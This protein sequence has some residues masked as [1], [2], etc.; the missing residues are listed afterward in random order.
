[1]PR[2]A[3]ARDAKEFLVGR[4]AREAQSRGIPLS[5]VERKMLYFSETGWT[6]PDIAEVTATFDREYDPAEFEAKIAGLIRHL[7]ATDG[8]GNQ[9]DPDAWKEAV[10]KIR[11][12]DHYLLVM[13]DQGSAPERSRAHFARLALMTL[14]GCCIALGILWIAINH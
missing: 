14:I 11:N 7:R 6:L 10:R 9:D 13:I 5:E 3:T 4:I 1:V 12:E 8:K 2:F